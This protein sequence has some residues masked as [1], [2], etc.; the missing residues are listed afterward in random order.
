MV[1]ARWVFFDA[2]AETSY[3][4]QPTTGISGTG[5]FGYVQGT[6]VAAPVITISAGISDQMTIAL[7]LKR[8]Y[9]IKKHIK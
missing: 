7:D 5:T 3:T 4:A 6:Y 2:D 9:F 1:T 8:N